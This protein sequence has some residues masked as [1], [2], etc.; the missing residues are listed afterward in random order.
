MEKACNYYGKFTSCLA[1][2]DWLAPLVSR[3]TV[4]WIFV[5]AGWGKWQDMPRVV[6]FFTSLGIP[7][8]GIQAPFVASVELVCGGLLFVGLLTR[9]VS[10]PLIIVMKVAILTALRSEIGSFGDLFGAADYLYI[11]VLGWLVFYGGGKMSADHFLAKR[12]STTA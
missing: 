7:A 6:E 4:G 3:V 2:L 5:Q 10:I 1:K 8:P 9:L 11:V 12:C